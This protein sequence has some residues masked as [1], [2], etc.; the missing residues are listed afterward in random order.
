MAREPGGAGEYGR[1]DYQDYT[2][3]EN[4]GELTAGTFVGRAAEQAR[5]RAGGLWSA[6]PRAAAK[7]A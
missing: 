2:S 5:F 7:P 3:P 6:P 1:A 4:S